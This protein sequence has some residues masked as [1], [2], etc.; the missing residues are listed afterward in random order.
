M[1]C[2]RLQLFGWG[3]VALGLLV[4]Y[5]GYLFKL[6][7]PL[8]SNRLWLIVS[9]VIFMF[10]PLIYPCQLD[11]CVIRLAQGNIVLDFIWGVSA[12]IMFRLIFDTFPK[13]IWNKAPYKVFPYLGEVSLVVFAAHRPLLCY[14]IEPIL[15]SFEPRI[16][17]GLYITVSFVAVL[18]AALILN[19][20][21]ERFIPKMIGK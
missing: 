18:F 7:S 4:Y 1:T 12:C 5:A 8:L 10:I 6:Y 20:L 15:D 21:L 19:I 16:Q 14:V 17:Y 3:N 9:L 11:F 13:E 2:N